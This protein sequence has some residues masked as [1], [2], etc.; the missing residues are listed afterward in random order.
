MLSATI[1]QQV[2]TFLAENY[3]L[4]QD[5][6]LE[7]TDSFLENGIIDSTGVLQLIAFL[8]ETYGITVE[9]GEVTPENL[10]SVN[11]ITT[12]L[13]RKLEGTQQEAQSS[14]SRESAQEEN[15]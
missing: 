5:Y 12:Y 13:Q 15:A 11:S 14:A 4:G 8:E 1:R 2:R 6:S 9:D 7:D 10:D 3:L